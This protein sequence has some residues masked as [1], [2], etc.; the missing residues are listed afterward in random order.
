MPPFP[1]ELEHVWE[2]FVELSS[3]RQSGM[4]VGPITYLE[5]EAYRRQTLA[6]LTAWEVKLLRRL[7]NAVR[8]MIAG[9][10]PKPKAK[11]GGDTGEPE[12]IPITDQKSI[13]GVFAKFP[14]KKK[15]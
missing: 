14:R 13:R 2:A 1:F 12:G 15:A 8:E 10:A 7:D 3:T 4:G 9:Q 11:G 5:I 6:D